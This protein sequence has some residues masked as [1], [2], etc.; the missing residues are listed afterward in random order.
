MRTFFALLCAR[1]AR[2]LS[3][4]TKRGGGTTLPGLIAEKVDPN[5]IPKLAGKLPQGVIFITGTNGKTTTAK[6]LAAIMNAAGQ[7]VIYNFAGSNLSRGIASLLV[8]HTTFGGRRS[9]AK[10]VSLKLTKRPYPKW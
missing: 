7:E 1:I 3:R 5:I 6:M 2:F 8:E 4:T 9:G 10:P